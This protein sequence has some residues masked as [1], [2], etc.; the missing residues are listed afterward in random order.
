MSV[1]IAMGARAV[2]P[3]RHRLS[4]ERLTASNVDH[5]RT[6]FKAV[7]G[8]SDD[9][10][11]KHHAGIHGLPMPFYC[12]HGTPLF[13]PWHRAYLYF[14]EQALRDQV[15]ALRGFALPWWDWT[16][17]Q[18][19]QNGIPAA[20]SDPQAGGQPNPLASA[21]VDPLAI[22]QGGNAVAPQTAR[23]EGPPGQLPSAADIENVLQ[24]GDFLDFSGQL[25]DIH[26]GVHVW[27]GGH[28]GQIPYAA[29]D[30]IFWSHHGMI[31]R[32]WR[33]WQV[34][35]PSA[36]VP[37]ALLNQA[38]PPFPMTVAQ[39]IDMTTLGYDYAATSAHP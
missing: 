34:R 27:V 39:T 9:R 32:I 35:H 17:P 21:E 3:V 14:F 10:G 4:I 18:S 28:M 29:Y 8:I 6:A 1:G 25:E 36:A 31:D 16:S 13:L 33:L 30:P 11:Y 19:H 22:Q 26:G 23:N 12:K 2:L 7:Q 15:R 5:V 38:L 37:G 20:Y 24:L